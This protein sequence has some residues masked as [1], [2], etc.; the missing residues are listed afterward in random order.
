MVSWVDNVFVPIFPFL[1][2]P[3]Y[4]KSHQKSNENMGEG[5]VDSGA[6]ERNDRAM[7]P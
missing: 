3:R 2:W 4:T 7:W 5:T 1:F 6:K